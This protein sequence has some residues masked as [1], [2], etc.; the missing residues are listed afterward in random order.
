M[1]LE[2]TLE[3]GN[4]GYTGNNNSMMHT[5][6]QES[7]H[8]APLVGGEIISSSRFPVQS[9]AGESAD[10]ATSTSQL[11]VE[12]HSL[13]DAHSNG[14]FTMDIGKNATMKTKGHVVHKQYNKKN[15]WIVRLSQSKGRSHIRESGV[16]SYCTVT[17][18]S[19]LIE[20]D[21]SLLKIGDNF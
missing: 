16:L 9:S 17:S 15:K 1:Q 3:H 21:I 19:R 13:E 14:A 20:I 11:K 7:T 8:I 6:H 2:D 10:W 12:T 5:H 18:Y 4:S